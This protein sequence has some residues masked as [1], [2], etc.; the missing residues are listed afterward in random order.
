MDE[1]IAKLEK[2][3]K[4]A[5]SDLVALH[6]IIQTLSEALDNLIAHQKLLVPM[7]DFID[8]FEL[9]KRRNDNNKVSFNDIELQHSHMLSRLSFVSNELERL[10]LRMADFEESFIPFMTAC[11]RE[12]DKNEAFRHVSDTQI[13]AMFDSLKKE[14]KGI[15]KSIPEPEK[16]DLESVKKDIL[17]MCRD[18]IDE[19]K[20]AHKKTITNQSRLHIVEKK[21]AKLLGD[22]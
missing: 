20:A 18:A 9:S 17:V 8:H 21:V 2:F 10:C 3:E 5:A 6:Q 16:L 15:L 22:S 12:N 13:P 11:K 1:R 19:S 7:K 4:R 14:I